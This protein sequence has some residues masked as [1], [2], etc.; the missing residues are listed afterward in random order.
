MTYCSQ[1]VVLAD[2]VR[3]AGEA[4]DLAAF[5]LGEPG[6]ATALR[7][8]GPQAVADHGLLAACHRAA[9]RLPGRG[10]FA[11]A[12]S[13]MPPWRGGGAHLAQYRRA[14]P[15]YLVTPTLAR[16]RPCSPRSRRWR[17]AFSRRL[18]RPR[19]I[20]GLQGLLAL[21]C[22]FYVF[23]PVDE[24]DRFGH[25]PRGQSPTY[26]THWA[27][28]GWFFLGSST[29]VFMLK[30]LRALE[31]DDILADPRAHQHPRT[32]RGSDFERALWRRLDDLFATMPRGHWL[33]LFER[34]AIPAGPILTMEEA[35]A[36]PHLSAVGLV[37]PGRPIGRLRRPVLVRRV[38]EGRPR[39]VPNAGPLPL[40]GLRVVELASYIAGPYVG[41][42]LTDLGADVVKVEPPDGDPFRPLGYGFVTWNHGKRSLALN[43]RD[44]ADRARLLAVVDGADV[45]VTNY[46]PDALDR[47]GIGREA[48][49]AR[50]PGLIHCTVSAFGEGGPLGHLQGFDPVVQAFAGIMRRQGGDGDPVK[51]Q[52]PATDYL[53][54]MLATTGILAART[55]QRERG[56]GYVVQTSL[57]A[58]TMLLNY[59]AYQ[60]IRAGRPY[61]RGG[62]DFKGPHPLHGH[63][64]A[65][66]GWLLTVAPDWRTP[67]DNAPALAYLAD[68]VARDGVEAAVARLAALGAAAVP[69]L[70]P[71]SLPADPHFVDNRLWTALDQPEMGPLTVP[72]PVFGPSAA[73]GPAPAAANRTQRRETPGSRW[74]PAPG[75][76]GP[77]G[78]ARATRRRGSE[79]GRG[80]G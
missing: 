38:G 22:G 5:V 57:L 54:A 16:A 50:N 37:E 9:Q 41:R 7:S 56:G 28:D 26:S 48:L 14:R 29:F 20:S 39:P 31:L 76:R 36:H 67:G 11:G 44:A 53:T 33:R 75:R 45:L 52:I 78:V 19:H 10:R 21:Q 65:A 17:A 24:H 59:Q 73:R 49:L 80:D 32:Q 46:R 27:A 35:I 64:R 43:L 66:D 68:G 60:D 25:S 51:P 58:A 4:A 42:L 77:I 6:A 79:G 1:D 71:A 55:A 74:A 2:R 34:A 72:A 63:H 3:H 15:A 40:S 69:C 8:G 47:M 13:T 70:E 12:L 30:T 23:G 61:L 18:P 62:A